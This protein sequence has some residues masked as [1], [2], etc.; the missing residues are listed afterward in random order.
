MRLCAVRHIV[1]CLSSNGPYS[2]EPLIVATWCDV[3]EWAFLFLSQS[4]SAFIVYYTPCCWIAIVNMR[5]IVVNKFLN[6]TVFVISN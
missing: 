6:K 3:A 4:D 2:D 1:D 5:V